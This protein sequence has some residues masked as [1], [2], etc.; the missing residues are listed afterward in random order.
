MVLLPQG[1]F[2]ELLTATPE[3][4]QAILQ[5]LF[6]TRFYERIQDG[7]KAAAAAAR[8]AMRDGQMQQKL[9]LQRAAAETPEAAAANRI[10][11]AESA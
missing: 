5:T 9:L 4:R 2:R 1:R 11:L 7:L 3:H 10:A 8:Q 6:R